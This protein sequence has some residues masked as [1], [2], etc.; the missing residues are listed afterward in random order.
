MIRRPGRNEFV[1]SRMTYVSLH[2]MIRNFNTRLY[3]SKFKHDQ[4]SSFSASPNEQMHTFIHTRLVLGMYR[5]SCQQPQQQEQVHASVFLSLV[6]TVLVGC[7]FLLPLCFVTAMNICGSQP[8]VIWN[9]NGLMTSVYTSSRTKEE[10]MRCHQCEL[11]P[12]WETCHRLFLRTFDLVL[13]D[14]DQQL[15]CN[16]SVQP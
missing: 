16:L 9:T 13:S 2:L 6:V 5:S 12:V 1:R 10:I 14:E 8:N 7:A 3:P 11:R 15:S 4:L